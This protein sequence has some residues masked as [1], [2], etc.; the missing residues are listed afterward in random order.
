MYTVD[1]INRSAGISYLLFSIGLKKKRK[2]KMKAVNGL[3]EREML[4]V[5]R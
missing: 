3:E 4:D 5:D 2:K 1:R